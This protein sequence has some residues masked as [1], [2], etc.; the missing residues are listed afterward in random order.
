MNN[1]KNNE[2]IAT[3]FVNTRVPR[4]AWEIAKIGR[5]GYQVCPRVPAHKEFATVLLCMS[6]VSALAYRL[7]REEP[8]M[9]TSARK[10]F[11]PRPIS[12]PH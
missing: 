11:E 1:E 7:T 10:D 12:F 9:K 3:L 6:F 5:K 8:I 2:I 4:K